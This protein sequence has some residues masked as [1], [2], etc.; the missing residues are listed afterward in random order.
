MSVRDEQGFTPMKKLIRKAPEAA[1][2]CV[3]SVVLSHCAI[4]IS[5]NYDILARLNCN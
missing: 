5:F 2:V 4:F 1:M 3:A